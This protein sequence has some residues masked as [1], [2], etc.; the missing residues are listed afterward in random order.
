MPSSV[1][2]IIINGLDSG[3]HLGKL[4]ISNEDEW[5]SCLWLTS[6]THTLAYCSGNVSLTAEPLV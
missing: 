3:L 1:D 4:D 2:G 5:N 6:S